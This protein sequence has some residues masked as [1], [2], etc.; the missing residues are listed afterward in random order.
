M[1]LL[2]DVMPFSVGIYLLLSHCLIS[3]LRRSV[4]RQGERKL[5][6]LLQGIFVLWTYVKGSNLDVLLQGVYVLWT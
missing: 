3:S 1:Q 4:F 6:A 5:D 2:I